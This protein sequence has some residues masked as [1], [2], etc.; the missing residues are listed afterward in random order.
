MNHI[1]LNRIQEII[2]DAVS[3]QYISGANC[4]IY[5]GGHEQGYWEAGMADRECG[6]KFSRDTICRLYS[7]SKPVTSTAVM[8]LLEEGK[9]DLM[10]DVAKFIPEFGNP[11]YCSKDGRILSSAKPVTIQDL[12]NM[13]S[14]LTY[15]GSS[16]ENEKQTTSLIQDVETDINSE[17][18]VSTQEF[19]SRL[20]KI[21]LAF[22]PG[23]DYQYGLSADVLGAVVEKVSGMKLG[24]FFKTRIFSPMSMDDTGFYVP[25]E[26]QTR[27]A[28]VYEQVPHEKLTVYTTS[29]LGIEHNMNVP[30]AYEAGGAGLVSTI[31]DYMNFTRML[32]ADGTFK[33]THVIQSHTA[34]FMRTAHLSTLLQ[35]SFEAK[36]PHLAGYTYANLLRIM[37][38]PG[39]SRSFGAAGEY[40]W[41]GWLGTFMMVDPEN[42]LAMVFFTQL[43]DSGMTTTVRRIKNVVYSAL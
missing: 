33:G 36:M 17:N 22:E 14:G 41:D 34:C 9:I 25:E 23:T 37:T 2:T 30:P 8:M 11:K 7:M 6:K 32:L 39:R 5:Q 21:P 42:D 16:N 3:S 38:D 15:G 35:Q 18:P 10:D 13:T 26:K 24:D 1:Q 29:Y 31:D 19:V 12:L 43:T 4:L 40:G 27:L 20:G 28:Q